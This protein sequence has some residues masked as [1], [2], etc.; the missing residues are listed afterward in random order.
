LNASRHNNEIAAPGLVDWDRL[1]LMPNGH[2]LVERPIPELPIGG[3]DRPD[4]D[5][6]NIETLVIAT[7]PGNGTLITSVQWSVAELL[8]FDAEDT[9]RLS[10]KNYVGKIVLHGRYDPEA[11]TTA[12]TVISTGEPNSVM[13][14]LTKDFFDSITSDG[15]DQSLHGWNVA[16][17]LLAG[18]RTPL[19]NIELLDTDLD[20]GVTCKFDEIVWVVDRKTDS[21]W[22]PQLD[23]LPTSYATNN[24]QPRRGHEDVI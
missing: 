18:F 2:K 13:H 10:L 4:W 20:R 17:E 9:L 19:T 7:L 14:V 23:P 11:K 12:Q 8:D 3:F 16:L 1:V 24:T 15:N 6:V 5:F 22:E 21:I